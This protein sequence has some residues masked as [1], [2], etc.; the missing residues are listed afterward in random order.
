MEIED[1]Y[2]VLNLPNKS[3]MKKVRKSY[4]RLSIKFHTY[5][6]KDQKYLDRFIMFY[7]AY[8]L[9]NKLDQKHNGMYRTKAERYKN[10]LE[11]DEQIAIE[12]AGYLAHLSTK[13]YES[14]IL[15]G[16]SHF[17][18][19]AY[20]LSMALSSFIFFVPLNFYLEDKIS[21]LGL[22]IITM[23]YSFPLF[24]FSYKFLQKENGKEINFQFGHKK[25]SNTIDDRLIR[26]KEN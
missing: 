18:K 17:T 9:L 1:Y 8:D 5:V 19:L 4:R 14:M 3:S 20:G 6:H 10:W 7:P 23:S 11:N 24:M 25:E 15:K 12:Q 22:I 13:E 2:K 21:L 16:F 26:K